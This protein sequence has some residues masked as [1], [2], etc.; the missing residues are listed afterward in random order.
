ME[1]HVRPFEHNYN[2]VERI[3]ANGTIEIIIGMHISRTIIRMAFVINP[4]TSCLE[5]GIDTIIGFHI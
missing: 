5:L 2:R 1:I 4:N 3:S